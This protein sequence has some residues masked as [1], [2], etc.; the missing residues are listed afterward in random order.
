M[1][2]KDFRARGAITL[3]PAA[4]APG[5]TGTP[6]PDDAAATPGQRRR[7]SSEFSVVGMMVDGNQ[8]A[9]QNERLAELEAEVQ[10]LKVQDIALADIDDNPYQPRTVQ[11]TEALEA[12]TASIEQTGLLQ[13][14]LVRPGAPGRYIVVA[15]DRRRQAYLRLGFERIPARVRELTEGEAALASAVENIAREDLCDFEKFGFFTRLLDDEIVKTHNE[16]ATRLGVARAGIT[17]IM[18][19]ARLPAPALAALEANP[20]LIGGTTAQQLA[21]W[22]KEHATLVEQA[23]QLLADGALESQ[24]AALEWI[25]KRLRPPSTAAVRA[26]AAPTGRNVFSMRQSPRQLTV[27]LAKDLPAEV[28]GEVSDYLAAKLEDVARTARVK[29]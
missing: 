9:R 27:T 21:S 28:L 15:G 10:A 23:V 8:M 4:P 6:P 29:K 20:R 14:I 13:P 7:S 25:R 1:T 24:S 5:A 19:F 3:D 12:L 2:M 17:F 18:A 26:F 16:L 22:S 11:D